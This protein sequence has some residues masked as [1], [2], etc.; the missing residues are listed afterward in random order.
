MDIDDAALM[1]KGWGEGLI[2]EQQVARK[3]TMIICEVF[4]KTM[5]GKGVIKNTVTF[6]ELPGDRVVSNSLI[7]K[8]RRFREKEMQKELMKKHESLGLN[9]G[10]KRNGKR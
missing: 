3:S 8:Y 6:W 5:G 4:N 2:Y 9:N 10:V 1:Y 7:D